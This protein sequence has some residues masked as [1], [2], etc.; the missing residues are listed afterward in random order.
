M[1]P[2]RLHYTTVRVARVFQK[3]IRVSQGFMMGGVNPELEMIL[4]S[5]RTDFPIMLQ[6]YYS[7]DGVAYPLFP[8]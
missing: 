8:H 4:Q 7:F 2:T 1:N 6:Y 3:N 5:G